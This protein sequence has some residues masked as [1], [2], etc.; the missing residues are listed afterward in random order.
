[1]P[2]GLFVEVQ[3]RTEAMQREAEFGIAAHWSYKESGTATH[4]LRK[5]QL[6]QALM[7]QQPIES[8]RA[9]SLSDHIFVLT[10]QGDI[11]ELPEGATP[12]DFA[13]HVHT[14][15]GLS[16]RAARVNGHIV[17]LNQPLENGDVVE[18]QKHATARPSPRWLTLLKTASAKARLK[19]FLI[20]ND[21]PL[22]LQLGREAFNRELAKHHLPPLDTDLSVLRKFDGEKMD[23]AEREE[24]LIK[25]G[26]AAQNAASM[27]QHLD[28]VKAKLSAETTAPSV[29]HTVSSKLHV[30][31]EGDIPM[32][33]RFARCCK[34]DFAKKKHIVG[35]VGRTGDVR[36]HYN[37]C[38]MLRKG[39]P[40]R[41]VKVR[42]VVKGKK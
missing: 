37:D 17:P 27:L 28:L 34:P 6:Q 10:P 5:A 39:N 40:E 2:E 32:P 4:A 41:R 7:L 23:L 33:V 11:I 30:E 31:V 1:V 15:L 19:R 24:M 12:L 8:T 22:Y 42:W 3:I 18:I 36:V 9:P 29:V 16:F 25:I 21:R 14:A 26:Q 13:F 35:V 20:H 38:K